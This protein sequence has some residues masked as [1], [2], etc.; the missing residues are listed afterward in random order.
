MD[1]K[2]NKWL[3]LKDKC[4]KNNIK[5]VVFGEG[6]LSSPIMFIGEALGGEE[7]KLGHPFIGPAGKV[8]NNLLNNIYLNRRNIYLTNVVKI[9][10]TMINDYG[11]IVN[12]TPNLDEIDSFKEYLFQE[13]RI[14]QPKLII[15]LGGI[16]LKTLLDNQSIS[17]RRLHG[18]VIQFSNNTSIFPSYHP[19]ASLYNSYLYNDLKKDFNSLYHLLITK[20]HN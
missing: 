17:I 6:K 4:K 10:P 16:A 2:E 13:L 12:R 8:F 7:E 3:I 11:T 14:I 15:A 9:R 19:A 20:F 18:H 5:K 1:I